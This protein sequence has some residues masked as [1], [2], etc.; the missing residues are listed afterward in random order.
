[1]NK[2]LVL[3]IFAIVIPFSVESIAQSAIQPPKPTNQTKALEPGKV[4]EECFA[5]VSFVKE[6]ASLHRGRI[7]L[8]NRVDKPSQ[9][10]A[11]PTGGAIATLWLPR[12]T[13]TR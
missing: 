4:I 10:V 13:K 6:I 1:M 11:Q 8:G 5:G 2:N 7:E 12:S 3:G 9:A